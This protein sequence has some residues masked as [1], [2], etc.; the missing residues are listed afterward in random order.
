MPAN[1]ENLEAVPSAST[2]PIARSEGQALARPRTKCEATC[3]I[4]Y[5]VCP[6]QAAL[7]MPASQQNPFFS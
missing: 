1:T 2:S 6:A 5:N 7:V 4:A 3:R